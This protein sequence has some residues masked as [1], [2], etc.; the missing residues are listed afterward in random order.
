MDFLDPN[1]DFQSL[2]EA[3]EG[4]LRDVPESRLAAFRR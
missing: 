3:A 1:K 2:R 4:F